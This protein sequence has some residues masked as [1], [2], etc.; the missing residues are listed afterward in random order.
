MYLNSN[1]GLP[2]GLGQTI[3][4]STVPWSTWALVG[5]GIMS[6]FAF[7]NPDAGIFTPSRK[8]SRR[9]KKSSGGS[10]IVPVLAVGLIGGAAYLLYSGALSGSSASQ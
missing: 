5:I 4:L 10:A 8:K 2:A 9:K 1:S 6:F 3:D 7:S